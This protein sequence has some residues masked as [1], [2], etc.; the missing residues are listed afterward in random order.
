MDTIIAAVISATA[1]ILV[2]VINSNNQSKKMIAE[3]DKHNDLQA[4]QIQELTKQVE[5]HNKVIERVYALEQED[6]VEKEEIK[7]INHRIKDLEGYHK[8]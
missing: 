2:C 8:P 7:V 4:Y 3:M 1:A 5:K 6:A